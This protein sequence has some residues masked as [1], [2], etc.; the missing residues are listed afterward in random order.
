LP[1]REPYRSFA[2]PTP[3]P[4]AAPYPRPQVSP[5]RLKDN[6]LNAL[7]LLLAEIA[8]RQPLLFVIEDLHWADPTTHELVAALVREPPRRMLGV[9]SARPE[10]SVTWTGNAVLQIQIGGLS[11][12]DSRALVAALTR[13]RPLGPATVQA[14]TERCDGVPLFIEEMA[15]MVTD[16]EDLG[17]PVSMSTASGTRPAI[18][19][20]L[21][22]MLVTRLDRLGRARDTAQVAAAIGREF[23]IDV[24]LAA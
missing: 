13:E 24:L 15:Y 2:N 22:G 16:A 14:P 3:R 23:D 18:P 20:T 17:R 11:S 10:L 4:P 21:R 12:E 7:A 8:D 9:W 5:Q 6:P 19:E 1:L